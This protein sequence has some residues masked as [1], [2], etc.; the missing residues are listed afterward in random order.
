M[1]NELLGMKVPTRAQISANSALSQE[2]Q[3]WLALP[4]TRIVLANLLREILFQSSEAFQGQTSSAH[5]VSIGTI[6][7]MTIALGALTSMDKAAIN[8]PVQEPDFGA[9]ALAKSLGLTD[10]QIEKAQEEEGA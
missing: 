10:K 7:G 4:M 6:Q 9:V 2:Y 5:S 3:H 1:I 8:E